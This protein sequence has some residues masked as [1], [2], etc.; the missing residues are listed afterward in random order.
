MQRFIL[1]T[2]SILLVTAAVAPTAQALPQVSSDFNL[3]TLRLNEF[4]TRD[5]LSPT[6]SSSEYPQ[7]TTEAATYEDKTAESTQWEAPNASAAENST[8]LSVIERRQQ[9]LDRS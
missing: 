6:P 1:S 8:T 5:R 7:A 2:V 3:Q 4:D 9:L